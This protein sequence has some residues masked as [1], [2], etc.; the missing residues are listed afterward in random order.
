MLAGLLAS[1]Q[2]A[3]SML[4]RGGGDS[5][6]A[7][8]SDVGERRAVVLGVLQRQ[9]DAWNRGDIGS[10]MEGYWRSPVLTFSSGGSV[11]RGWEET[12]D[13]YLSRYPNRTA[14]G[15]LRFSDLEILPIT[16]G[17]VLV[18]GRWHLER[19]EPI[20]GAFSLVFAQKEGSWVIVHDHTSADSKPERPE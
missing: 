13:R 7:A 8:E 17:A 2:A 1:V 12:R 6:R 15:R 14:M 5:V 3:C 10:F 11:Q 20:G 4:P 19:D 18:L 16:P 9:Q